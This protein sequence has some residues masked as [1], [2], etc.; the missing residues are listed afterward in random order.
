MVEFNGHLCEMRDA[1]RADNEVGPQILPVVQLQL[2]AGARLLDR[3]DLTVF[4]I[5]YESLLEVLRV[6]V[7]RIQAHRKVSV[8][9][10]NATVSAVGRQR[11]AAIR[12]TQIRGEAVRLQSHA[13]GH[14]SSPCIDRRSEDS[15]RDTQR[16][17]MRRD[18][19][20]IRACPNDGYVRHHY[21]NT[22]IPDQSNRHRLAEDSHCSSRH[23]GIGAR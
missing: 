10:R 14:V 5:G 17:Q 22:P 20:A 12:V 16:S 13:R 7:E 11:S 21:N 4:K 23:A 8:V 18:G 6:G 1:D 3:N 19:K 9:V 15:V 2:E